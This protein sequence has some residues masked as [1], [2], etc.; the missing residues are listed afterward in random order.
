M[1]KRNLETTEKM[2]ALMLS[3]IEASYGNIRNAA[4]L[5]KIDAATHYRWLK[6]DREYAVKS[7]SMK[8][9]SFR[10]R[11]DSLMDMAFS[12][13]EKG[14]TAIVNKLLGIYFKKLPEEIEK[15]SRH[16]NVPLMVKITPVDSR[17]QAQQIME[18]E[19][20]NRMN[21]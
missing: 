4:K 13:A 9:I 6:E 16:N 7:E 19:R 20:L 15:Y 8:D 3:A 10:N 18:Q 2:K 14:N 17:E 1:N 21:R 11:K 5:A 12:M